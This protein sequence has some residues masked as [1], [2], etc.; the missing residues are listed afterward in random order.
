MFGGG[1]LLGTIGG[2]V[3]D[4]FGGGVVGG[5]ARGVGEALAK[6]PSETPA[7]AEAR[8]RK[9]QLIK[10][11]QEAIESFDR[12]RGTLQSR[13]QRGYDSATRQALENRMRATK[14][15]LSSRG[16]LYSGIKDA[17][18]ADLRGAAAGEFAQTRQGLNQAFSRV[19]EN[20]QRIL[21]QMK[22]NQKEEAII[23]ADNVYDMAL[24]SAEE[25]FQSQG[26]MWGAVGTGVGAYL[27]SRGRGGTTGNTQTGNTG[28]TFSRD[29]GY[30]GGDYNY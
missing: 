18:E 20:M 6:G 5:V 10:Q 19:R 8:K 16:L 2:A 25:G 4:F 23:A 13:A 11:Q 27:G 12:D 15:D 28:V 24:R 9:E 30:L 22:F 3:S 14:S 17:A 1:G 29:R 21:D 26:A 7:E